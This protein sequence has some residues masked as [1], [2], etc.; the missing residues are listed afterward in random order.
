MAQKHLSKSNRSPLKK[1]ADRPRIFCRILPIEFGLPCPIF[2][3]IGILFHQLKLAIDLHFAGKQT[4]RGD[5][6]K[7][8]VELAP[9]LDV[10]IKLLQ[11][12]GHPAIRIEI[13]RGRIALAPAGHGNWPR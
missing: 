10:P 7:I 11:V 5:G 3:V 6:Q 12:Q 9:S 8:P 4:I 13:P 1:S 2:G